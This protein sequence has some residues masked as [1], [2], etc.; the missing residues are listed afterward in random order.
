VF[1]RLCARK[2]A[3]KKFHSSLFFYEQV[4]TTFREAPLTDIIYEKISI[5]MR[6][7]TCLFNKW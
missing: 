1:A 4:I 7:Y 5:I 6:R 3:T 2:R